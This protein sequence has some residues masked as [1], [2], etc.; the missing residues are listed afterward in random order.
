MKEKQTF[1][2]HCPRLSVPLH[3]VFKDTLTR[4][5]NSHQRQLTA[6]LLLTLFVS[7]L[8]FSTLHVHHDVM[9]SEKDCYHCSHHLPHSGHLT[10]A[11]ANFHDCLLCQ[12]TT[13]SYQAAVIAILPT[14][15]S[16]LQRLTFGISRFNSL[17]VSRCLSVR[18]P[19]FV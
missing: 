15:F 2:L 9:M 1:P 6:R 7:M 13:L 8:T 17:H 5:G 19:P 14:L 3:R 4:M 10:A 12:L 11:Q 18:A 16:N